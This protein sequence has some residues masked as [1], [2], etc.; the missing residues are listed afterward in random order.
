MLNYTDYFDIVEYNWSIR[1]SVVTVIMSMAAGRAFIL[2]HLLQ[3]MQH[4]TSWD[5]GH[6]ESRLARLVLSIDLNR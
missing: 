3:R 4:P 6:A 2:L 5:S 1:G